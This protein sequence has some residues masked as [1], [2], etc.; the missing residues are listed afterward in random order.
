LSG[1]DAH[2]I[3][4]HWPSFAGLSVDAFMSLPYWRMPV[5]YADKEAALTRRDPFDGNEDV[6]T[7]A[8][9]L[10]GAEHIL[11]IA[12]SLS[13]PDLHLVWGQRTKLPQ[14]ILI[15]LCERELGDFF[16]M[17]EKTL[18]CE[19][20]LKGLADAGR[21]PRGFRLST[22]EGTVDF[23]IDLTPALLQVFGRRDYLDLASA[24]LR[25]LMRSARAEYGTILLTDSER[26]ALKAGDCLLPPEEGLAGRWMFDL[27]KDP[28]VHVMAAEETSLT[29]G[30]LLDDD[31]PPVPETDDVVLVVD[32][33]II[34]SA[35][36]IRLGEAAALKLTKL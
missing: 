35:V 4:E 9:T 19:L 36:R 10:N 17:L 3:L 27:P 5:W 31:V 14:E 33:M 32:G 28:A 8:V 23:D 7:L 13:F 16:R 11:K 34:A 15:A 30:Q 6:L 24:D 1:M 12:D 18:R 2:E 29:F 25:T 20:A 21:T 22:A 26:T